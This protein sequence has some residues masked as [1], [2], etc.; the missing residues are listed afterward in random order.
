MIVFSEQIPSGGHPQCGGYGS[1]GVS[2]SVTI[3]FTFG[4]QEEPVEALVLAD[5]V[6]LIP[7]P[8]KHLV[9]I[10]LVAHVKDKLVLGGV[11]DAM[12]GDRQ[13]HNAEV[14]AEMT[15]GFGEGADQSPSDVLCQFRQILHRQLFQLRCGVD[16]G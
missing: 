3:V 14:G 2:R 16:L 5:R 13:F 8:R 1:T 7:A 6:N 15:A 9:D 12:E 10:P 4:A 11:K